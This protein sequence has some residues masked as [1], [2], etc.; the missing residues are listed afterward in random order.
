MLADFTVI[1]PVTHSL[2][3]LRGCLASLEGLDYPKDRFQVALVDCGVIDGLQRFCQETL[4]GLDIRAR[5]L[6]LPPASRPYPA[7]LVEARMNEA[8]NAAMRE[9][10]AR[11][12]VFTEDDCTFKP[13]WLERIGRA[14]ADDVGAIGGPDLLPGRL[15]RF[16]EALDFVLNSPFGSGRM[17]SGKGRRSGQYYPRKQNM[18]VPAAVVERCGAFPEERP[19]SGEIDL[20]ARARAAGLRIVYLEDN[21]VWHRRISTLPMFMR[22]SAYIAAQNVSLLKTRGL[23]HRSMYFAVFAACLLTLV[24]V[25]ASFVST[26]ALALLLVL[27]G[28][29]LALLAASAIGA[30]IRFA[31]VATA[32]CVLVLIPAHHLSLMYGT[33]AGAL[34]R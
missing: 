4:G 21:P 9:F 22:L 6:I 15:G 19:V 16:A 1:V 7:W 31:S 13:D 5:L 10:P 2:A 32:L 3:E 30:G 14:L 25:I 24:L 23:F 34:A 12:F 28:C 17:R 11:C 20:A 26:V 27:A 18:A 33:A 29:Y 8:R